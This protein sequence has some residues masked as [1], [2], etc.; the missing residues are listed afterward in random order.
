MRKGKIGSKFSL[1]EIRAGGIWAVAKNR[2]RV[3]AG[4]IHPDVDAQWT[5]FRP[6]A[7]SDVFLSFARLSSGGAPSEESILRW[8]GSHGLLRKRD[9]DERYVYR[10]D[11]PSGSLVVNQQPESVEVFR[12]ESKRAHEL[13]KL[14]QAIRAAQAGRVEALDA[15]R[16]R[17]TVVGTRADAPRPA[18]RLLGRCTDCLGPARADYENV[19]DGRNLTDETVLDSC[20]RV[21]RVIVEDHLTSMRLVFDEDGKGDLLICCPDLLTAMYYQFAALVSGKTR[22]DFCV[23]CGGIMPVERRTRKTCSDACRK[24]KERRDADGS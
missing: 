20:E 14:F 8:V 19:T 7:D 24:A 1:R 15:L 9:P 6:L 11:G 13:L 23:V 10:P 22:T 12:D 4:K 18:V 3:F 2:Y 17:L 5:L 16:T 21:L